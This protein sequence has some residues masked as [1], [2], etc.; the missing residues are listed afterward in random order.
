MQLV[1][2]VKQGTS[3]QEWLSTVQLC[4]CCG[5]QKPKATF[6]RVDGQ[7]ICQDCQEEL[8]TQ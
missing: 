7:D 2:T 8:V 1:Y 4:P 3:T 5:G 6:R